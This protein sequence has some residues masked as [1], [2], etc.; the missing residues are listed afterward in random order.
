MAKGVRI[1]PASGKLEFSGSSTGPHLVVTIA[2]NSIHNI[3]FHVE[4]FMNEQHMVGDGCEL[5][6]SELTGMKY[7]ELKRVRESMRLQLVLKSVEKESRS[8]I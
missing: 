1:T 7:H 2:Q 4:S 3:F 5:R 6:H 8:K